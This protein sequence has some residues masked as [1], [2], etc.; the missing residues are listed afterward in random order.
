M[1]IDIQNNTSCFPTEIDKYTISF[2]LSDSENSK[3]ENSNARGGRRRAAA[4]AVGSLKEL[5]SNKKLRQG[6]Q[7]FNK[8]FQYSKSIHNEE[9]ARTL[10][11]QNAT[12]SEKSSKA[13]RGNRRK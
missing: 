10:K 5:P 4:Q 6:D 13:Q 7:Q 11:E 12:K 9:K 1:G 8:S 2:K 3:S